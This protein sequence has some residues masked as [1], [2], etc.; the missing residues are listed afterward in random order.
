MTEI[1]FTSR[2]DAVFYRLESDILTG[3]Y[4]KGDVITKIDDDEVINAAYLK[5][6]LY[7]YSIGDKV[8]VTYVR[9]GK[10]KTADVTLTKLTD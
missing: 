3:V 10:T 5:Y 9:D 1:K 2:A 7:K 8:K 6:A 4:K